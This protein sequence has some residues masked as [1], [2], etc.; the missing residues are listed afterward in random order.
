MRDSSILQ[1]AASR[2]NALLKNVY[3]WMILGVFA[4]G[5]VAFLVSV[6]PAL[7]M[8]IFGNP[9]ALI[10][11]VIAEFALVFFLSARTERMSSGAAIA[12]FLGYAVLTGLT[13]GSVFLVFA[14]TVIAKA[15]IS[16]LSVFV[17]ASLYATFSKRDVRS[18]GRYLFMALVGILVAT[19]LNFFF[20]SSMLDYLISIAGVVIFTLLTVWDTKKILSINENYGIMMTNDELTKIGILGA[21]DLYLD[22]I[23]IFLYLV[24]IFS[25]HD[26]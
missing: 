15:F 1:S 13:L 24:Q 8:L 9:V 11:I 4:S 3:L 10:A 14:P 6:S 22:F 21:L 2:E 12:S 17:G 5:V 16:T 20:R 18:W 26:N 25:R 7:Q 19:L 23:N